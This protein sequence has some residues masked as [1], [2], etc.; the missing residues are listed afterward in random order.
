MDEPILVFEARVFLGDWRDKSR[1]IK[2][3][4]SIL[5]PVFLLSDT[6][7]QFFDRVEKYVKSCA[8]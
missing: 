7:V 2:A 3:S 5:R 1:K 8:N 6:D 4:C